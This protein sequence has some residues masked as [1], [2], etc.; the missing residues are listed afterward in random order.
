MSNLLLPKSSFIHIPK[1]AG[2]FLQAF[3]HH[4]KLPIYRYTQ[5]QDGH[6]FLH[7]MVRSSNT[8]NFCFVRHPYTWWPSFYEWSKHTRFSAMEKGSPNFDVWLQDY[9]A[10]WLGL[11][12]RLVDRY[13]GN[14]HIYDSNIK[15]HFIGKVENLYEDL[16]T[17]LENANENFNREQF[18]RLV[19]EADTKESLTKWS[20]K[21]DYN[22][23]ISEASKELI[24]K[25]E[26]SIFDR[27][28]YEK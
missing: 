28:N 23:N 12:T 4:L 20:N 14:D 5:P 13:T 18:H 24:Y 17:A 7:Q 21:Q 15:V 27:F 8:Y 2:T 11:Y 1:C 19:N 16:L 10:F 25:A 6:L 3:L 22:K 26:K 9:G